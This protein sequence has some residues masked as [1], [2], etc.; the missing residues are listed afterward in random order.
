MEASEDALNM[1]FTPDGFYTRLANRLLD[2]MPWYQRWLPGHWVCRALIKLAGK[3]DPGSYSDLVRKPVRE[4][5]LLLGS[6]KFIA[7]TLAAATSYGMK[8]AFAQLPHGQ[9]MTLLRV[10]AALTCPDLQVCPTQREIV[11]EFTAPTLADRLR[12]LA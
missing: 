10:L 6:P 12:T 5:L 2:T 9:F 7:T 8:L 3:I 4:G 11:K 1:V